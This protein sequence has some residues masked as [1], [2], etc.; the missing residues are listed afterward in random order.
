[1]AGNTYALIICRSPRKLVKTLR[2]KFNSPE[3]G[4][5]TPDEKIILNTN[6]LELSFDFH[7]GI[8]NETW[9]EF[10]E[11]IK[12]IV[13]ISYQTSGSVTQAKLYEIKDEDINE[14]DNEHGWLYTH[15]GPVS[16][17]S[18]KEEH[19]FQGHSHSPA[20]FF[21]IYGIKIFDKNPS[22]RSQI[23]FENTY[24]PNPDSNIDRICP[25]CGGHNIRVEEWKGE[26]KKCGYRNTEV[27]FSQY[28]VDIAREML[29]INKS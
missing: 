10:L 20:Y 15:M 2:E 8:I 7:R 11:G 14:V 5:V 13:I 17:E 26:C 1:M 4:M 6:N 9:Y 25:K 16:K 22:E 27:W 18:P 12:K 28:P 3:I 24:R 29:R 21:R 19:N 23:N